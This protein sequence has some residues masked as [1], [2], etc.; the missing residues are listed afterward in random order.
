MSRRRSRLEL[1]LSI[2]SIVRDGKDKPTHIMYST[3]MSWTS[4]QNILFQLVELGLLEVRTASESS[5]RRYTITEKG[6]NVLDYFE[7]A[8]EILLLEGIYP[9]D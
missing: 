5:R 8:K 2:L 1:I 9:G 3:N 6:I 4:T 7:K